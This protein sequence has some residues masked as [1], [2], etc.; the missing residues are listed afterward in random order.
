MSPKHFITS[1]SLAVNSPTVYHL[2]ELVILFERKSNV[3]VIEKVLALY[4]SF[5]DLATPIFSPQ[6]AFQEPNRQ[7]LCKENETLI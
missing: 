3:P 5:I 1:Y 4:C 6:T 7:G 2:I